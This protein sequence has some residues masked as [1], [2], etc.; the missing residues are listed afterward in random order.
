[1]NDQLLVILGISVLGPVLGSFIGV[2]R[3]PTERF[4]FNMLAF[5]GGVMLAISFLELIPES[6][7]LS[8][9]KVCAIGIILGSGVMFVYLPG[10]PLH[11]EGEQRLLGLH[12][13]P[14][15]A[16]GMSPPGD[17]QYMVSLFLFSSACHGCV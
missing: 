17:E 14:I 5:A 9:E 13:R 10:L 3:K 6:I 8:S 7:A 1:M 12:L 11:R 15:Q 4:M 16:R 2:L